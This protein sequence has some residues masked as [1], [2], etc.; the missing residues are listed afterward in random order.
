MLFIKVDLKNKKGGQ[1]FALKYIVF[2]SPSILEET[3]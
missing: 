3:F 2:L 1:K